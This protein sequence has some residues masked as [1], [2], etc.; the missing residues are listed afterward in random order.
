MTELATA[1]IERTFTKLRVFRIRLVHLECR[2]EARDLPRL[3]PLET[4]EDEPTL[5]IMQHLSTLPQPTTLHLT[6]SQI[7]GVNFFSSLPLFP[8]LLDF[9]LDFA[10]STVDGKWFFVPDEGLMAKIKGSDE[11]DLKY[12]YDSDS[13]SD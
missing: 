5:R 12:Y 11:E 8:M 3:V 1:L 9:Q 2:G 10:A 6:G 7:V 13:D 4:W